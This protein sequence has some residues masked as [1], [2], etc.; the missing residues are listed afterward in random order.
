MSCV[1]SAAAVEWQRTRYAVGVAAVFPANGHSFSACL[2]PKDPS[3]CDY[4]KRTALHLAAGEGSHA[5]ASWLLNDCGCNPNPIDR[6][7]RTPLEEAV[8]SDH[9]D[10]AELLMKKGAQSQHPH[11]TP[12]RFDAP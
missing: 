9:G 10:I 1:W 8:R 5:V 7:K 3:C 11:N 2:Q 12:D 4:D 6:F